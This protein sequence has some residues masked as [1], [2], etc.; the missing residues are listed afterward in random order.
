LSGFDEKLKFS[1]QAPKGAIENM[2][3]GVCLKAYPDTKPEL[4]S[5]L[6]HTRYEARVDGIH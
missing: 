4:F 6:L 2:V 3:I 1:V 5:K